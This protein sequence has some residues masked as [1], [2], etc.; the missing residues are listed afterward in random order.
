[1][2]LILDSDPTIGS[3]YVN[4]PNRIRSL[5]AEGEARWEPGGGMMVSLSLTRQRVEE[6]TP[7][8]N[9][10]FLNAP[11]TMVQAR[12]LCPLAGPALRLGSELI[13]DSGRPFHQTDPALAT[14]DYRTDD[15]LLWNLSFSGA[16]RAYHLHYFAGIF[17]LLDVR[18]TRAGF[19]T[20]VDY[21]PSLIPRYGRSVRTSLSLQF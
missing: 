12:V 16:Y 13:L 10:P 18:D 20:S 8:G 6:M 3:V 2:T 4:N 7:A 5:G 9:A 21:P 11:Q 14:T 1:V 19:P 17:N 15:A